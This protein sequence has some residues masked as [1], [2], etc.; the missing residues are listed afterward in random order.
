MHD[1]ATQI[2]LLL[3]R[4][5]QVP[6][7]KCFWPLEMASCTVIDQPIIEG[8]VQMSLCR[9]RVYLRMHAG[10]LEISLGADGL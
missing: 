1:M 10:L 9:C 8:I 4:S 6:G 3:H 5:D 7:E 2:F